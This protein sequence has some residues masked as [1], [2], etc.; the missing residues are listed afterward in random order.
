MKSLDNKMTFPNPYPYELFFSLVEAGDVKR[1]GL[2]AKYY[3]SLSVPEIVEQP[4][5]QYVSYED[6]LRALELV[7][8]REMVI[9]M[10]ED[11]IDSIGA[12]GVSGK[13]MT[14]PETA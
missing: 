5:G 13:L 11:D 14:K 10:L 1:Y 2:G 4:N 3:E 7:K 6:Y 9:K 12:G 8:R